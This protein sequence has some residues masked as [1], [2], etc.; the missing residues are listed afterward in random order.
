MGWNE[1]VQIVA[2]AAGT[3]GF[4]LAF[5][6]RGRKIFV[7]AFGGC[8]G[9][10]L[11]LLMGLFLESEVLRY[12]IASLLVSIYGEVMARLLKTPTIIFNIVCLVPFV[13]GGGLYYTMTNAFSGDLSGFLKSGSNTLQLAAALSLGVVIV[14][15]F[16]A[17]LTKHLHR[18]K[19]KKR[20]P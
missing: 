5:N 19:I 3:L 16:T 12:F 15:T 2:A 6:I 9:W 8:L 4:A 20:L 11:F 10:V 18:N 7:A 13:P 1:F 14:G 17:Y